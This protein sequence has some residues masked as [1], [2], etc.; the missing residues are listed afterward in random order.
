K[1]RADRRADARSEPR[2][3]A[4][5]EGLGCPVSPETC[6]RDHLGLHKAPGV[7]LEPT[8]SRLTAERVCQ[9]SYPGSGYPG[10]S[11]GSATLYVALLVL[12]SAVRPASTSA[13]QFAQSR[14]HLRASARSFSSAIATPLALS[15]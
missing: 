8:T 6:V 14:M 10:D 11:G 5:G 2:L 3:S 1:R 12:G 4:A 15:S 7:G 13:W 9:L